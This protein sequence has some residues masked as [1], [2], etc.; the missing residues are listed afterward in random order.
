M[1]VRCAVGWSSIVRVRIAEQISQSGQKNRRESSDEIVCKMTI[2]HGNKKLT[3]DLLI[4]RKHFGLMKSGS[5]GAHQN[6]CA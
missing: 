2:R 4:I 6:K 3:N 1:L 5:L